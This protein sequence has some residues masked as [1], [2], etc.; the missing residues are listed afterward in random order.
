MISVKSVVSFA[1]GI[2]EICGGEGRGNTHCF[3]VGTQRPDLVS[4]LAYPPPCQGAQL[5]ARPSA[6]AGAA[7]ATS[8]LMRRRRAAAPRPAS[9]RGR[10]WR[11]ASPGGPSA[12]CGSGP[13]RGSSFTGHAI[14]PVPWTSLR[15]QLWTW[16]L[17]SAVGQ[18]RT[19]IPP[20]GGPDVKSDIPGHS[21]RHCW[22]L[23]R[24]TQMAYLTILTNRKVEGRTL[25][26]I[27]VQ[28]NLHLA[29]GPPV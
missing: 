18:S 13:R 5:A 7:A 1:C 8:A 23:L 22:R 2:A 6:A 20:A 4:R 16:R 17:A 9:T 14:G 10:S 12:T 29:R 28:G 3:S 27:W 26:Y 21:C 25:P 19:A 15:R 24:G 11:A